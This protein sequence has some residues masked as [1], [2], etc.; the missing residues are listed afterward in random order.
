MLRMIRSVHVATAYGDS[1]TNVLF[2][3]VNGRHSQVNAETVALQSPL[4]DRM[5]SE[6]TQQ[7]Q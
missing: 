4:W 5:S 6:D 7:R 1:L 2:T 3:G